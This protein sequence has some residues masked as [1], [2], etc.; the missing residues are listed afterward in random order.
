[1]K[2]RLSIGGTHT[3]RRCGEGRG[4]RHLWPG[5]VCRGSQITLAAAQTQVSNLNKSGWKARRGYLQVT[6][7]PAASRGMPGPCTPRHR[8]KD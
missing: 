8:W 2:C 1:M 4:G 7:L 5:Q 3:S 6:S